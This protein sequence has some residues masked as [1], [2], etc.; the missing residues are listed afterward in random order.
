MAKM[1]KKLFISKTIQVVQTNGLE[2]DQN[3]VVYVTINV[4]NNKSME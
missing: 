4:F 2:I 1:V 3:I